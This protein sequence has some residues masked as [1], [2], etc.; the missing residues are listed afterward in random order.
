MLTTLEKDTAARPEDRFLAAFEVH[1]G[2]TLNG[3]N[4]HL[5]RLRQEAIAHFK[6]LGFPARKAE[7]WKYT[8]ITDVLRRDYAV[9]LAPEAALNPDELAPFLIPDL[10]AYRVVLLNGRF[11]PALSALD[12]LPEGVAVT[13]LAGAA[14]SHAEVFNRHF[15]RYADPAGDAFTALNTAFVHDGLFI[16][17]PARTVVEK[18]VHVISLVRTDEPLFLQP[19]QLVVVEEGARLHLIESRHAL[20]GT[21][22]F[23]S[24]VTELYTGPNAHVD[25]YLIQD[26]GPNASQVDTRHLYQATGSYA[27]T[28]TITLSGDV[29]RNNHGYLPDGENCETHLLGLFLGKGKLHVDN[30]T[31]VDHARPRCFSNELF[32]GILDDQ[33]TGVFN[34]KVYVRPDAQQIN[35]YQSNKSVLLSE[36]A[37]MYSKPELEIYADDVKCSHGATTGQLDRE[38]LFYLRTRGLTAEQARKV[39]LLA[40][41]RDVIDE[42]RIEPLRTHLD[43]VIA[44]RLD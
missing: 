14:E 30:H 32:K 21:R 17:V 8:P 42:I 41:A 35:A 11:V 40:F 31:L 1:A 5:Q 24:G 19:R 9:R 10:D 16:H 18:P 43:E 34:G 38:A 13:S 27:S 39:L 36:T 29:V 6:R 22:T 20:S 23:T 2:H 37:Q 28:N 33:A 4:P 12:G 25:T 44:L 3:S 7:A 15:G 26:E